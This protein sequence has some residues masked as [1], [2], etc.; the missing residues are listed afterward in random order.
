MPVGGRCGAVATRSG[1]KTALSEG[2]LQGN[3][4][5]AENCQSWPIE[6]MGRK[7]VDEA[8]AYRMIPLLA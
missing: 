6:K 5:G 4:R 8:L 7:E 1:K 3:P 2:P